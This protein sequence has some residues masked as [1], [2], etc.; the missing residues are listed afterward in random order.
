LSVEATERWSVA[1]PRGLK[2]RKVAARV[3]EHLRV[4]ARAVVELLERGLELVEAD[5]AGVQDVDVDGAAG[6]GGASRR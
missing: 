5:G 6:D 1:S 2:A 4:P 3:D